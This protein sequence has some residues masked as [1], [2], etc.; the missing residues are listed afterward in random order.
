MECTRGKRSWSTS[1][2]KVT[3]QVN[4][5]LK[6]TWNASLHLRVECRNWDVMYK[7]NRTEAAIGLRVQFWSSW[8]RK[9]CAVVKLERVQ[10]RFTRMLHRG[11]EIDNIYIPDLGCNAR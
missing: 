3:S 9:D 10:I 8:N 7:L 6:K 4:R 1:S 2:L 11:L 5:L